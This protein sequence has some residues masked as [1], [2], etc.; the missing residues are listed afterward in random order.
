MT[1]LD[2]FFCFVVFWGGG[3]YCFVLS[4]KWCG[5]DILQKWQDDDKVHI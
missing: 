1:V 3:V 4:Y 2:G 5:H